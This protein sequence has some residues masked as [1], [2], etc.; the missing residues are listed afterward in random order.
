MDITESQY[1]RYYQ[2]IKGSPVSAG[3][4]GIALFNTADGIV[5][6]SIVNDSSNKGITVD[7]TN[8]V[9][10]YFMNETFFLDS[11]EYKRRAVYPKKFDRVFNIIFSPD[12]FLVDKTNSTKE[13]LDHLRDRGI[14]VEI[15]GEYSVRDSTENDTSFDDYFVTVE[16]YDYTQEVETKTYEAVT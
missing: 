9:R 4:V 5:L 2:V 14:L 1:Q 11:G 3:A 13:S 15:N 16:P 6:K 7:M 12:D 10:E 8:T